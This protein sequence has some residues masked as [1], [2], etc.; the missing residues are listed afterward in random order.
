MHTLWYVLFAIIA[1]WVIGF[2]FGKY[3]RS[4]F[5]IGLNNN[6]KKNVPKP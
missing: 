2:A 6:L 5:S 1:W 3:I 4:Q